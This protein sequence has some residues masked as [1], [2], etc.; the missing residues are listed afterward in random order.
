MAAAK[1]GQP[2]SEIGLA[3]EHARRVPIPY[4]GGSEYTCPSCESAIPTRRQIRLAKPAAW[5]TRLNDILKC[6]FCNFLFSPRS[7]ATVMRG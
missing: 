1:E 2:T 6:P 4:G 7:E 3:D 5:E